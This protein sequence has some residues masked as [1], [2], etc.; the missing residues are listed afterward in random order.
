MRLVVKADMEE[1]KGGV[2]AYARAIG[3]AG[4]GRTAP[5]AIDSL[6]RSILAWCRGLELAGKL[7]IVLKEKGLNSERTEAASISVDVRVAGNRVA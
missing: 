1:I 2:A 5:D 7:E 4:H 6:Q 3:L